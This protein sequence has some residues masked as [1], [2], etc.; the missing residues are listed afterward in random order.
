MPAS[1]SVIIVRCSTTPPRPL[2]ASSPL[3]AIDTDFLSFRGSRKRTRPVDGL[4]AATGG[5]SLVRSLPRIGSNLRTLARRC[6]PGWRA[7]RLILIGAVGG[8]RSSSRDNWRRPPAFPFETAGRNAPDSCFAAAASRRA[9]QALQ[10]VDVVGVQRQDLGGD[11]APGHTS[12]TAALLQQPPDVL[13]AR[14]RRSRPAARGM[15]HPRGSSPTSLA[16]R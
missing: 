14:G 4:D 15:Q 2:P 8:L 1:T 7:R 3:S 10:R 5:R 13:S 11:G 12:L 9:A 16:M 6:G